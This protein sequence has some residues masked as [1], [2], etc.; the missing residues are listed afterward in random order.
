MRYHGNIIQKKG[1]MA[2]LKSANVEIRAK[3]II[4]TERN[5]T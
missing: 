5:T 2:L 1:G 4:R 3:K